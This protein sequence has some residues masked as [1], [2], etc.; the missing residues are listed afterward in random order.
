[1][2]TGIVERTAIVSSA[3]RGPQGLRLAIEVAELRDLPPWRP[4]ALGESVAVDGVCL[5]AVESTCRIA[6]G[7]DGGGGGGEVAF[8]V[9]PETLAKTTLGELRRGD[10]VN[11]ERS[12]RA[13]DVFGG[14]YVSGH[15]D[16]TGVVE[17][18][19][20]EGGQVVFVVQAPVGLIRQMLPKGSVAV[21]GISLTLVDVDRAAAR[22]SFAAVP[23]TLARTKLGSRQVG[24]RV[25]IETDAFGKWVLAGLEALA[26]AVVSSDS[27]ER[28]QRLIA[29]LR[30]RGFIEDA[31]AAGAGDGR[32]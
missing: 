29:L 19:R 18:R 8:D 17:E 27:A 7:G 1:V 32:A 20:A 28:D 13:G 6:G 15:V 9:V 21:D 16:G 5:T 14:H 31:G 30:E 22:F 3:E 4:V 23:H 24:A 25:N 12:L 10:L 26:G 2:F 11:V